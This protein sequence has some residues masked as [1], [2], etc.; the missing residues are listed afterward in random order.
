MFPKYAARYVV[1]VTA[2]AIADMVEFHSGNQ[3]LASDPLLH[4]GLP[5]TDPAIIPLQTRFS[6]GK[7][8][9]GRKDVIPM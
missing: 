2:V 6:T 7:T 9:R 1:L 3:K 5:V 4:H 8:A